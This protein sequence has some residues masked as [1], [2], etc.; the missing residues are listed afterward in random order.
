MKKELKIGDRET[1][2]KQY[3]FLKC[4][5]EYSKKCHIDGNREV[6]WVCLNRRKGRD[7]KGVPIT[8][9]F[10]GKI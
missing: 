4:S 5:E 9:I 2:F 3:I 6:N 8:S 10:D 7:I 1:L